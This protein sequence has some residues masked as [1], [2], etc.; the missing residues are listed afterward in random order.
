VDILR[1]TPGIALIILIH[2][3]RIREQQE[4]AHCK[5]KI[6]EEYYA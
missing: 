2:E 3:L 6:K 1:F 4:I 5:G